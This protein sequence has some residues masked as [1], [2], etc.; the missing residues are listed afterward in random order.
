MDAALAL[1]QAAPELFRDVRGKRCQ[2]LDEIL[3]DFAREAGVHLLVLEGVE[4]VDE[5]H[6]G[7]D[8]RV[9]HEA[10]AHI[11][12]DLA[13]RHVQDAAQ[14]L[15]VLRER[16]DI[17]VRPAGLDRLL[18]VAEDAPDAVEEAVRA[19]DALVAPLEVAVDRCGEQ[20]EE[21][22]RVGAVLRDDLLRR[23]D[24]A[25]R[26]RHLRTVL[27]DHAL[28]QEVRERLIEVDE[29]GVVQDLRE[30]ARVQEVQDGVLDAADVLIDRRPVID[31]VL[32]ERLLV[33]VRVRVA[34]VV[35]RRADEGVHR[36]RLARRIGAALRALAVDEALARRQWRQRALVK[37]DIL[38]QHDRQ[39]FLRHEDFAA[40]RA[41]D[42]RDRRTPVALARDEPVAQAEVDAA[43]A[44][45]FPLGLVHDALHG[46]L[47]IEACEF[48]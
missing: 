42:D 25:L 29:A 14:F 33:V 1:K 2:E 35:P 26:L 48:S 36:V 6:D 17:V 47:D 22:G 13:D 15:L 37:R 3:G 4:G 34:Q 12:R 24:I 44:E 10:V 11:L 28:R 5:L 38:W 39:V 41:V 8:G 43:L 16:R 46:F 20:D 18:E 7:R 31:L 32:G 21:A 19:F 40:V 27:E 9:E 23:D 30:E 45:A